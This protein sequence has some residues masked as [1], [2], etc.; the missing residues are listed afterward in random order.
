MK[1]TFKL[2]AIAAMALSLGVA[3]GNNTEEPADTTPVEDSVIE[4]VA[5]DTVAIDTVAEETPAQPA[6]QTAKKT[7]SKK[8]TTKE[9]GVDASKAENHHGH[10]TAKFW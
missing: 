6:K 4:E 3:C 9:Q 10:I 1:R 7:T 5:E 8:T 2:I